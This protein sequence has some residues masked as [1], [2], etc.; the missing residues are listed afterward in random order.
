MKNK[1]Y[2]KYLFI[3]ICSFKIFNLSGQSI[4]SFYQNSQ[5]SISEKLIYK[6]SF[7]NFTSIKPLMEIEIDTIFDGIYDSETYFLESGFNR[8]LPLNIWN[9]IF[10]NHLI[11]VK[12]EN[13]YLIVDPLI[14]FSLAKE[15][16]LEKNIWNNTRGFFVQGKIEEK[17]WFS[18]GFYENQA[19]FIPYLDSIIFR[20][21]IIPGQGMY[22]TYKEFY[23]DYAYSFGHISYSP[24]KYFNF[25]LGHGKN[26]WGDGYRSLI[27]SDAAFNYPYFRIT[28]KIWHLKY[29]NLY[30]EFQDIN[31]R[32]SYTDG[33]Q[34]K[35]GAFHYLSW[36][37]TKRLELS[38][39]EAIIWQGRDSLNN[40]GFDINYLNPVIFL[41]PVEFSLGSPDNA[42]MGINLRYTLVNNTALYGQVV[43]DEFT[44]AE[45]KAQNGYWGNKQAFQLGLKSWIPIVYS[46]NNKNNSSTF[47][48]FNLSTL[49][50]Q[51]EFNYVRPYMYT[52]R[53][54]IQ[55][56]GHYNQSLAHPLGA[57]FMEWVNIVRYNYKR[58]FVEAKYSLA[59]Y[60]ED[61]D[62]A[63]YG[64][65][66]YLDYNTRLKDYDNYVTQGDKTTL[67][68]T[69]I[70]ISWLVNPSHNLHVSFGVSDVLQKTK[71]FNVHNTLIFLGLKTSI[72]N[73]YYDF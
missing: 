71:T 18:F 57:N 15:I 20:K 62:G 16:H 12:K 42:L 30:A 39:F 44:F 6:P 4:F 48:P 54:T 53:I 56:Y 19:A 51:S 38:L 60:G 8:K 58:F 1:N 64:R 33:W 69:N 65:N 32:N 59:W 40:R 14:N 10:N 72:R 35:Y 5:F 26:F 70:N 29:T 7:N 47:Q 67:S 11:N 41:R 2:K 46:N 43:I 17:F 45:V 27:L 28:T 37:I 52:H 63:N 34:K 73:I 36:N 55:N 24:S 50:I 31:H 23:Y 13:Y 21:R 22:K 68:H 9:K 3:I 61:F 49:Y 25:Q 66:I